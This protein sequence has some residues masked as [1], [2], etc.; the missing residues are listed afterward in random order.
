MTEDELFRHICSMATDD[1]KGRQPPFADVAIPLHPDSP[2]DYEVVRDAAYS[3]ALGAS[4][5]VYHPSVGA[6]HIDV[7]R[8]P[9]SDERE[10]VCYVTNGMSDFPLQLPDGTYFR[11][12]LL[13]AVSEPSTSIAELLR[14]LAQMPFVAKTFLHQY[15]TVPLPKGVL[16]EPFTF[17][18]IIPPFLAAE[19]QDI[20]LTSTESVTT[21]Q[22]VGITHEERDIAL[23]HGPAHLVETVLPDELSTWLFDRRSP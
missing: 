19:L 4:D 13:A 22:V 16:E 6:P 8:Y 23:E 2:V 20:P 9:K 7:Y 21:L 1:A 18:L 5:F 11:A 14:V 3:A 17:A 10:F 12:E 15:H